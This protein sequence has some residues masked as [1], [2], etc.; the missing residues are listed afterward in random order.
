MSAAVTS[1]NQRDRVADGKIGAPAG[2]HVRDLVG[3]KK[4]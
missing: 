3:L 2:L 1:R 4:D